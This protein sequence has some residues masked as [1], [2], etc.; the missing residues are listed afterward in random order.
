[1]S[2]DFDLGMFQSTPDEL[3]AKKPNQTGC[4]VTGMAAEFEPF[5]DAYIANPFEFSGAPATKN[6]SST[7]R[8]PIIGWY[9]ITTTLW[10]SSE[11]PRP[12]RRRSPDI[13]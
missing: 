10:T 5:G 13:R 11:T 1:M 7:T 3:I 9:S 2:D 8:N 6:L 12:S 4:P